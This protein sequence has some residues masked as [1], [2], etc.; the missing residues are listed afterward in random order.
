MT[1]QTPL[2]VTGIG[3]VSNAGPTTA[4]LWNAMCT[5]SSATTQVDDKDLAAPVLDM[6][7]AENSPVVE[8][9]AA[10][11]GIKAATEALQQ[12]RDG[13]LDVAGCRLA[14]V[15]G[16]GMGE[17]A[18]HDARR[19]QGE[20]HVPG[21]IF[22][23]AERIA[24]AVGA[25]GPV[26]SISNACAAGAYGI[27]HAADLLWAGEADAV[28]VVGAEAYSR[29][30]VACFNRMS[31]LDEEGCRPFTLNR[32]GTLFGEGAGAVVMERESS[33]TKPV[34][35]LLGS[36][37]S[38]DAGH[39]TAPEEGAIQIE[40]TFVEG[41]A[42]SGVKSVGAVVPHGTG[43]RLNDAVEAQLLSSRVPE[44]AWFNLKALLGHTGGASGVLSVVAACLITRYQKTPKNLDNGALMSEATT[45][46]AL[47]ERSIEGAVAVNAYAFGGNNATLVLGGS[48][49]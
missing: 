14:V 37:F 24:T 39:L 28:L 40:R 35:W 13:G 12:A 33:I 41:L 48:R 21:S 25:T 44:A 16:T 31:A 45:G 32:A 15:V 19:G 46:V 42:A 22:T 47:L 4:D 7:L 10:R 26:V 38:C 43:T 36:A 27:G 8:H 6:F 20:N 23:T 3:A 49:L 2:R 29:V 17:A 5:S 1:C 18:G 30:A 11:F 9:S 34:S